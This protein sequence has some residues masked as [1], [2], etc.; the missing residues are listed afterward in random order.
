MAIGPSYINAIARAASDSAAVAK[1]DLARDPIALSPQIHFIQG[2]GT[3]PSAGGTFGPDILLGRA[4]T[5]ASYYLWFSGSA[6]FTVAVTI[7][8]VAQDPSITSDNKGIVT[9]LNPTITYKDN[10]RIDLKVVSVTGTVSQF[11]LVFDCW[12]LT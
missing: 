9:V 6:T 10:A 5:L 8:G 3:F 1:G 11:V 4:Y 2:S 12:R 7:D